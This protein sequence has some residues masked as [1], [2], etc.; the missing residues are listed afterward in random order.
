MTLMA[1]IEYFGPQKKIKVY[2]YDPSET[3]LFNELF[4]VQIQKTEHLET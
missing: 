3:F 4:F 1:G 2:I